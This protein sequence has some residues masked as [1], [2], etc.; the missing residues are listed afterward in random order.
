MLTRL[1]AKLRYDPPPPA[2]GAARAGEPSPSRD[3][4]ADAGPT[5]AT[6]LTSSGA[7]EAAAPEA[8]PTR[9]RRPP[10]RLLE[11]SADPTDD[12]SGGGERVPAAG[13][14]KRTRDGGARGS[15]KKP[16]AASGP[17]TWRGRAAAGR[18]GA[19]ALSSAG[20][21][22]VITGRLDDSE[23]DEDERLEGLEPRRGEP[24]NNPPGRLAAPSRPRQRT[25]PRDNASILGWPGVLRPGASR[26]PPANTIEK[27]RP[28]DRVPSHSAT[29]DRS[30]A[31]LR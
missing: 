19:S 14:A 18:S 25:P 10:A 7:D 5:A 23:D 29:Q 9:D 4:R 1:F 27:G 20:R 30:G 3:G 28:H 15:R 6:V 12:A 2:E 8:R 26:S 21:R 16:C 11:P 22:G 13:P 31:P 17:S 24:P